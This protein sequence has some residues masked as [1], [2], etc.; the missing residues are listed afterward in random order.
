VLVDVGI[1][2]SSA[3]P[4]A[5]MASAIA[6]PAMSKGFVLTGAIGLLET[7][8]PGIYAAGDFRSGS[9]KR[10]VAAIGGGA[11]VVRV[12]HEH[13]STVPAQSRAARP[14]HPRP[15]RRRPPGRLR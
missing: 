13:L 5:P 7:S 1:E 2:D 15:E 4:P 6:S 3:R 10:C 9:T 12:I 11:S 14:A 8:V